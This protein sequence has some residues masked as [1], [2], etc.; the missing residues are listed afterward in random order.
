MRKEKLFG[1]AEIIKYPLGMN[2][3]GWFFRNFKVRFKGC[4]KLW[5]VM[6]LCS[7]FYEEWGKEMFK[8]GGLLGVEG[9]CFV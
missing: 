7:K 1:L 2:K 6:M 3:G 5:L 8:N 9:I 4:W